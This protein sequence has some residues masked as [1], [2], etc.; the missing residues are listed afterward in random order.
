MTQHTLGT[1]DQGKAEAFMGKIV[2]ILNGASLGFMLS[3]GHR[4]GLFDTLAGLPPATSEEIAQAAGLNERYV[5]EWLGAVVTG[6]IVDYDPAAYTYCLPPEH[7]GA[8]TR[9]AGPNNLARIAQQFAIFGSIEDKLV[10]CFRHGGGVAYA[11]YPGFHAFV[12]EVTGPIFDASL[13]E[14]NLPLVNGLT[15][16]LKAGIDV[17][18]VGCG[19]GHAVNLMA[20]AFPHSRFVGYDFSAAGIALARAEAQAGGLL[21]ARFEVKDAATLDG[22]VQ[23]DLITVFDAIHDQVHPARVL[24]GIYDSLKPGGTFLCVD[25]AASSHLQDNIGH[26]LAPFLYST[27]T[28]HCMTVSLASHGAGL[29]TVWGEQKALEMLAAAG[30]KDVEVRRVEGDILN[31]YYIARK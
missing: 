25:V 1:I 26:P 8:L 7:A 30:F 23:F 31:N 19:A 27:S 4:T 15:D 10:D 22:T 20:R 29:G 2:G 5:R 14:G 18:D 16:R 6:G 13:I 11:E 17:A 28:M 12:R 24:R 3:I 9:A 21:N